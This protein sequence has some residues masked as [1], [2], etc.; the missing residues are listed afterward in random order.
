MIK[1]R[2]FLKSG[3][4][5]LNSAYIFSSVLKANNDA[6]PSNGKSVIVVGA[7]ISG[8]AAAQKLKQNGF[9]VTVLEAQEKVG[10][11]MR[12]NRSLGVAFDEGAG[13]IHTPVGNPIT[14]LAKSAGIQTVSAPFENTVI[15]DADG[16]EYTDSEI[17]QMEDEFY[18]MLDKVAE[19]Q[20]VNQSFEEVY[21]ALYPDKVQNRLWKYML[22]S[23]VEFDT[24][25]DISRISSA[26]FFEEDAFEGDDIIVTNGYDKI[27]MYL[28]QNL[29][30]Q[31]NTRV[32]VINYEGKKCTVTADGKNFSADYVIVSVPLGVL[33]HK[34]IRF[35]PPL[36]E[37]NQSAIDGLG[38][39]TV[40]KFFL[41][42]KDSFWDENAQFIGYTPEAKGKFN[43]FVNVKKFAGVNALMTFTFGNYAVL[44]EKLNDREII[45]EIL[46]HLRALYGSKV[47][48]PINMLR[49]KWGQNINSF[50]AYISVQKRRTPN[51]FDAVASAVNNKIFFAA[52]Y[53]QQSSGNTTSISEPTPPPVSNSGQ[54]ASGLSP[55]ACAFSAAGELFIPG[56][57]YAVSG[58][59]GKAVGYGVPRWLLLLEATQLSNR[60]DY[61][62]IIPINVLKKKTAAQTEQSLWDLDEGNC[63]PHKNQFQPLY[64]VFMPQH[65]GKRAAFWIPTG[66]ALLAYVYSDDYNTWYLG[67]GLKKD[68]VQRDSVIM[69]YTT[70]IGEEAFFRGVIQKNLFSL[71][72]D[73]FSPGVSYHAGVWSS[74]VIFGLAHNGQGT[75]A[76]AGVATLFGVYLGYVYQP[77]HNTFDLIT[78]TAIHSV[79][80][81]MVYL[82]SFKNAKYNETDDSVKQAQIPIISGYFP[83]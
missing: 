25:D 76:S 69:A 61:Q 38:M 43:Y 83:F 70:G 55:M 7:G 65:Y 12:T 60:D 47:R 32:S 31:L 49:T 8:L 57:G 44:S 79:W 63:A 33:K 64:A 15:Y 62:K 17:E 9:N 80:N 71:Y 75:S 68:T 72:K 3:L 20:K 10:G 24:G 78:T 13:W 51:D 41:L 36:P 21:N 40:N 1:R 56:L 22:S 39:G 23:Y 52:G 54:S 26:Y 11:R 27:P 59:Y 34:S 77:E 16:R 53:A 82:S 45:S 28:A 48:E 37:Q 14:S 30:V 4:I 73:Y 18:D 81:T 2:L 42:W 74:A 5:A 50:G 6:K 66:I 19:Q 46:S 29:N 35:N 58:Q 67:K